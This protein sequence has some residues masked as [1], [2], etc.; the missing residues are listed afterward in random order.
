MPTT[1]PSRGEVLATVFAATMLAAPGIF[2]TI[3]FGLP[4]MNFDQYLDSA[5][6]CRS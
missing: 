5:R 6:A 3:T 2:W 4:G 1:V